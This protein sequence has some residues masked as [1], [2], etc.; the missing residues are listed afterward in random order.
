MNIDR[1]VELETE[2]LERDLQN[3][4]IDSKEYNRALNA[5]HRE[6]RDAIEEDAQRAYDDV[7]HDYY[8]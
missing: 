3:G 8:R 7:K 6:A 1:A 2:S 5:L 4:V